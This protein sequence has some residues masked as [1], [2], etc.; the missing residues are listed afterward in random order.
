MSDTPGDVNRFIHQRL[1]AMAPERRLIMGFSMLATG[2][3]LTMCSIPANLPEKERMRK[4]YE[5]MYGE[6]CPVPQSRSTQA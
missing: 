4:L 3:Q 2:R 5:R 1:M 6:V